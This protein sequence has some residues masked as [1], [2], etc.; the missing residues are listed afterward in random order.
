MKRVCL[1]GATGFVG[2]HFKQWIENKGWEVIPIAR[3]DFSLGTA[4]LR[5]LI[6]G[7]EAIVHLAGAPIAR[8]WNA[9]VKR[10]LRDS[11]ILTTRALRE[12][13][14]QCS[15]PPR[16]FVSASAVGIYE[17]IGIHDEKSTALA[18][19]FLGRLCIDWEA[20][21]QGARDF[22]RVVNPRIGLVLGKNG[23]LLARQLP[24]F[25]FG[26][27]GPIG[28]GKQGFPFIHIDDLCEALVF[29]IE[30]PS[31]S[32]PVNLVAPQ[33]INQ[34]TFARTLGKL[35]HRP[36]FLPVPAF[37]LYLMFGEG[38]EAILSGQYVKPAVLLEVD[39]KF[40]YTDISDALK[41]ILF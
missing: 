17:G 15:L 41:S 19:D 27:G 3:K 24:L 39:F 14:A 1:S 32:G 36:A 34:R 31:M 20:E 33:L 10:E 5:D 2:S 12:A 35:L 40:K 25:K 18:E 28:H 37:A 4:H 7:S 9:R 38:A 23:G 11:R 26:L 16:V 22:T 21:A 13:I 30:N 8:R 29:I 6:Q